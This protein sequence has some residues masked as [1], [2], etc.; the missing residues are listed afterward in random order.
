MKDTSLRMYTFMLMVTSI[1]VGCLMLTYSPPSS[2]WP[3][4]SLGDGCPPG[5]WCHPGGIPANSVMSNSDTDAVN[6]ALGSSQN[7]QSG[8][9]VANFEACLA[10]AGYWIYKKIS[11]ATGNY[12]AN[13]VE[14]ACGGS[15]AGSGAGAGGAGSG[16]GT[17]D[18]GSTDGGTTGGSTDTA[19]GGDTGGSTD[20]A[21]GDGKE[22]S[23]SAPRFMPV[24]GT[25]YRIF[26]V[27]NP[28]AATQLFN[29]SVN[30]KPGSQLRLGSGK[31]A[32]SCK[33]TATYVAKPKNGQ[34]DFFMTACT[35][36]TGRTAYVVGTPRAVGIAFN[37]R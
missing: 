26:G 19:S 33:I 27:R 7:Q 21:D 34:V 28:R 30:A 3:G 4:S 12:P 8:G 32:Q 35:G 37:P 15:S 29:Q 9:C 24:R 16:G 23:E 25:P 2:A 17:D 1:A 14:E 36:S 11:C 13:M 10:Q 5:A 22:T 18:G 6:D 31:Y 20:T